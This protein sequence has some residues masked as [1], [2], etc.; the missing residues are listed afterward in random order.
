MKKKKEKIQSKISFFVKKKSRISCRCPFKVLKVSKN[1]WY[2]D[3][4]GQGE[5]MPED[6]GESGAM[7]AQH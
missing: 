3:R 5:V 1:C 6:G 2:K 4:G 7:Q